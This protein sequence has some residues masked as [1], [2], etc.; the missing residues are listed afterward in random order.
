MKNLVNFIPVD[1]KES[2]KDWYFQNESDQFAP[3]INIG[4]FVYVDKTQTEL[5]DGGTYL[6]FHNND[7]SNFMIRKV[8]IKFDNSLSLHTPSIKDEDIN[9]DDLLSAYT[10]FGRIS[11]T[12][13]I[14]EK[15]F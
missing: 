2:E 7:Q 3:E 1:Q 6:F 10:V 4:D 11:K 14:V 5:E 8:S 15:K 9:I 12:I 13:K